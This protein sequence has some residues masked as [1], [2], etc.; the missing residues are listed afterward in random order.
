MKQKLNEIA[1]DANDYIAGWI[2]RQP[3]V[4]EESITDW[5]L[6]YFHQRAPNVRY[7]EFNRIEEARYT[8]A[9]W[10]WWF[11]LRKGCFKVRVQAKKL[12]YGK[13]H[14]PA[15]ARENQGGCQ[16]DLLLDSIAL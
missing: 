8:G 16:I 14:F 3:T 4:K 13:D 7:Y 9:D 10:D 11:L 5:L 1:F 15:L 12:R 2:Q 6:D